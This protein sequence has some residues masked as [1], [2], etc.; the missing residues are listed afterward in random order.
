MYTNEYEWRKTKKLLREKVQRHEL[1]SNIQSKHY[2]NRTI[3]RTISDNASPGFS[4]ANI[5]Y[6]QR[7]HTI[8]TKRAKT[9]EQ[10]TN[11]KLQHTIA[12]N[13]SRP[14]QNMRRNQADVCEYHVSGKRTER[15]IHLSVT[16]VLT[17]ATLI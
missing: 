15:S 8:S 7:T 12:H 6:I 10:Q 3:S 4:H 16:E 17:V 11:L 14:Q 5:S 13:K 1:V 9:N 2:K